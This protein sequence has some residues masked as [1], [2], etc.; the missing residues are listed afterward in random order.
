MPHGAALAGSGFLGA[1]AALAVFLFALRR[2]VD[3]LPCPRATALF[4]LL[5]A[6][7]AASLLTMAGRAATAT[8]ATIARAC[9]TAVLIVYALTCGVVA[10]ALAKTRSDL[11]RSLGDSPRQGRAKAPPAFLSLLDRAVALS[12]GVCLAQGARYALW[13]QEMDVLPCDAACAADLVANILLELAPCLVGALLLETARRRRVA[14]ARRA[15]AAPGT[16]SV[17]TAALCRRGRRRRRGACDPRPV[18]AARD[19]AHIKD[20]RRDG[21]PDAD[22]LAALRRRRRSEF[23]RRWR[24][25]GRGVA[26]MPSRRS[27][28]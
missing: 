1:Y 5:V 28:S 20:L 13:A 4:S 27:A 12:A 21:R 23:H 11:L 24:R 8:D 18:R 6:V 26:A 17:K 22:R 14:A 15:R 9:G 16:V 25:G 7:W 3:G 19:G 10:A 2:G